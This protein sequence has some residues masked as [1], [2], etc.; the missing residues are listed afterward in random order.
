MLSIIVPVYNVEKYLKRCVDSLVNQTYTDIEIILVDDG[1]SD[2]SPL[3]CDDYA[4]KYENVKVYHK[5]NGGAVSA[6][7]LGIKKS[8]GDYIAF[9]D[10]DDW[11]EVDMYKEMMPHFEDDG[12]NMVFCGYDKVYSDRSSVID[13][14]VKEGVYDRGDLKVFVNRPNKNFVSM[15][16]CNKIFKREDILALLPYLDENIRFAEDNLF[17]MTYTMKFFKKAYYVDKTLYHYFFNNESVSTKL[18][19]NKLEQF[20][21]VY[22]KLYEMDK[23]NEYTKLINSSYIEFV[24]KIFRI[25][26]DSECDKKDKYALMKYIVNGDIMKSAKNNCEW[27]CK[28]IKQKIKRFLIKNKLYKTYYNLDKMTKGK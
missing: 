28:G 16:R 3:I 4:E 24:F 12:I 8:R 14:G 18:N 6:Y 2:K 17:C 9:I 13:L 22:E 26:R 11:V 10:S 19:K 20:N 5:Q 7:I 25:I 23:N 15:S 1:S 21:S 27:E